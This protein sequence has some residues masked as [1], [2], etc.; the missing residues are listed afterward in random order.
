MVAVKTVRDAQCTSSLPKPKSIG[1]CVDVDYIPQRS[2]YSAQRFFIF[3]Y[4]SFFILG[5]AVD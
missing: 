1:L 5:R 3:S 4:F 2:F